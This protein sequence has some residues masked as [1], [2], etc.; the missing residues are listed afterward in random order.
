[1]VCI[2]F[3]PLPVKGAG[4]DDEDPNVPIDA[5]I[6]AQGLGTVVSIKRQVG[7]NCVMSHLVITAGKGHSKDDNS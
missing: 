7:V 6:D 4:Y 1:M 5:I 3:Y 2:L